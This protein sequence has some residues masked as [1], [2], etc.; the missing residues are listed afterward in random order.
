[1]RSVP[2]TMGWCLAMMA[3]SAQHQATCSHERHDTNTAHKQNTTE[4][5]NWS[6]KA[7]STSEKAN[8]DS[9]GAQIT[10]INKPNT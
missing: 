10:G 7:K 6:N 3:G 8:L 4:R 5:L 1:M 2:H 9:A